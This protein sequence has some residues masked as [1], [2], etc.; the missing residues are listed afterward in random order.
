MDLD[1]KDIESGG[2]YQTRGWLASLASEVCKETSLHVVSVHHQKKSGVN[3]YYTAHYLRPKQAKLRLLAKM[4]WNHSDTEG[5]LTARMKR[6]VDDVAPDLVHI[7][8]SEKQYLRLIPYL[9]AQ[10]IPVLMSIQGIVSVILKKFTAAYDESFMK[11]FFIDWGLNR[12]AL[13]PNRLIANYRRFQ[14]QAVLEEEMLQQVP[15]FDGRTA[16]DRSIVSLMNPSSTYFHVDRVLKPVFYGRQWVPGGP[17]AEGALKG[18]ADE[19]RPYLLHTTTGNSAYKGFEVIAEAAWLLER[20]GL[21]F[22]WQIAGLEEGSWSVRAA[23]KKLGRRFPTR[24]LRFL[25]MVSATELVEWLLKADLYV[26]ASHIE[27]SPNN[28]AEAMCLGMPCVATDVGGTRSYIHSGESGELIPPGDPFALAGLVNELLPDQA[29]REKLGER[30]RE[31]SRVRHD[32]ERVKGAL[33]EVYRSIA[34]NGGR[35]KD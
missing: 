25:G 20:R 11:W 9:N 16:W 32:P 10:K 31:V 13:M 28:V 5:D 6:I 2:S 22:C 34:V 26:S 21:S 29:R 18:E 27:N 4:L 7:H 35:N 12:K 23:R 30:A 24:S 1:P 3:E 19:Q 17:E 15:F 8:G 14:R 33:L